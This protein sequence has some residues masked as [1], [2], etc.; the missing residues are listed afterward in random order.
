MVSPS[1][2][3]KLVLTGAVFGAVGTAGQR[4]TSTR[5]LIV[6]ESIY[7]TVKAQLAKAYGQLRIGNPLDEHNHVGPLIDQDA[8][9]AYSKAIEAIKQEGGKMLVE[10]GVLEGKGYESGCYV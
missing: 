3:L 4:C 5:R 8:V 9:A 7:D 6:H 10:G 1:A 2:D